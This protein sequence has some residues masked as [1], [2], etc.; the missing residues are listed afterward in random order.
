MTSMGVP[1]Q[2]IQPTAQTGFTVAPVNTISRV[3]SNG[4]STVIVITTSAF[5]QEKVWFEQKR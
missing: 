3:I 1:A 5:V 2:G 4:N